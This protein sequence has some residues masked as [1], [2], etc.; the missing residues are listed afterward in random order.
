MTNTITLQSKL[1]LF[2]DLLVEGWKIGDLRYGIP[3]VKVMT[4]LN[5]S[6]QSW[7]RYRPM[8]IQY[9]K[10]ED[11]IKTELREDAEYETIR[12]T[13]KYDKKRKA[14]Y[15]KRNQLLIKDE[16][17][18]WNEMNTGQQE[19]YDIQWYP[20]DDF[21]YSHTTQLKK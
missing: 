12:I 10:L 16:K 15:G 21:M 11:L 19:K 18:L 2:R 9:C 7:T 8:I 3:D 5:C 6:P 4:N 1:D 17:G 20:E 13:M 14:W